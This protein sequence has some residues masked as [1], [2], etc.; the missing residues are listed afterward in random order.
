MGNFSLT[1][2][3]LIVGFFIMVLGFLLAQIDVTNPI[4]GQETS[5]FAMVIDWI[6]P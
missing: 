4:T 5:I 1:G 3:L 6:I 2:T